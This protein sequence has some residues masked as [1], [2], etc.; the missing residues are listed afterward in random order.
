MSRARKRRA[1][2]A[3]RR[4]FN[5]PLAPPEPA[6]APGA[7]NEPEGAIAPEPA[8]AAAP[9]ESSALTPEELRAVASEIAASFPPPRTGTELVLL[10]ISPHRAHAYWHI[11]LD[12]Y[13]RAA[14]ACGDPCPPLILRIHDITGLPPE[15]SQAHSSFDVQVQ[16]LQGHWYVDLW[17]DGRTYIG[18]LGLRRPDGALEPLA[19]SNPVSTPPSSESSVYHTQAID[20]AAAPGQPRFTDLQ[21]AESRVP[22]SSMA[23]PGAAA[24]ATESSE[25]S[26]GSAAA[27]PAPEETPPSVPSRSEQSPSAA[28][29]QACAPVGGREGEGATTVDG[30]PSPKEFPL[31]PDIGGKSEAAPPKSDDL[32]RGQ[33]LSETLLAGD[34]SQLSE[35]PAADAFATKPHFVESAAPAAP[36]A[37]GQATNVAGSTG[38]T[39]TETAAN[40]EPSSAEQAAFAGVPPEPGD[41]APY[42]ER[43]DWPTA[44]QLERFVLDS[45]SSSPDYVAKFEPEKASVG[46]EGLERKPSASAEG[47]A[48]V[49]STESGGSAGDGA[50]AVAGTNGRESPG[51][52]AP[53][54]TSP[55]GPPGS[56]PLESYVALFSGAWGRPQ[57]TLEVN[58]ELHIFGRAQ[59]G[60]QLTLYGQ[61]VP[62]R[63]DGSFSVRRPLPHGAIVLPLLAV[64]SPPTSTNDG[65]RK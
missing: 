46:V 31:P 47:G 43:P 59:P 50:H 55:S 37:H 60:S 15:A 63:P 7:S 58:V 9:D 48:A 19:R 44:E 2:S 1:D 17:R 53:A 57:V 39:L 3:S 32:I 61:P 22:A 64:S 49:V 28:P 10:E 29:E 26:T 21:R 11:D 18:E 51:S 20:T 6:P 27:T 5:E 41:Q 34:K 56:L 4:Q 54:V 40:A 8:N 38:E 12:D 24:S 65:D 45:P 13:R 16:G 30:V 23:P 52:G 62:L 33:L 42:E 14:E 35:E 25:E 36:S